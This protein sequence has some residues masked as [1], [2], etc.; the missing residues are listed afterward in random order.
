MSAELERVKENL[1]HA[2][3]QLAEWRERHAEAKREVERRGRLLEEAE[4]RVPLPPLSHPASRRIRDC[5]GGDGGGGRR[6]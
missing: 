4:A 3:G 2:E 5:I 6:I 1:R